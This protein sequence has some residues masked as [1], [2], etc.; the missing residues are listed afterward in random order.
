MWLEKKWNKNCLISI[1]DHR[2]LEG[3]W[4]CD[5]WVAVTSKY[6]DVVDSLEE[7]GLL[8]VSDELHLFGVHYI[9]VPLTSTPSSED[10][11]IIL[12]GQR[13]LS[14]LNSCGVWDIYK[15]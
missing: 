9:F 10:E 3:L 2:L 13:E 15:I 6:H 14:L 12:Y 1:N 4:L 7:G 8:D 11:I 5:V